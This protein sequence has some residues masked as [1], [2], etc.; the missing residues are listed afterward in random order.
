[1]WERKKTGDGRFYDG[2]NDFQA[3][4]EDDDFLEKVSSKRLRVAPGDE[5]EASV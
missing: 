1:V 2:D 4:V 3:I 5:I